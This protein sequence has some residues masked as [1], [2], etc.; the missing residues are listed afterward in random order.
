M[1]KEKT[2]LIIIAHSGLDKKITEQE[3]LNSLTETS[4][5]ERFFID[6]EISDAKLSELY[7]LPFEQLALE[8]QRKFKR[9]IEP[10][11]RQHPNATVAYFGLAP[12][13]LAFQLGVLMNNF[14]KYL[15]F[16]FHHEKKVWYQE[17]SAVEGTE[18]EVLPVELPQKPEKGKGDVFIRVSAS[19]RIEP[20]HTLEVLANPTNE[21]DVSLKK[22]HVDA[23]ANQDRSSYLR[24]DTEI[25]T[26]RLCWQRK[27]SR[28]VRAY[29][30]GG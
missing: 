10:I 18:F 16:Q 14:S 3:C 27:T 8:Q 7:G 9:E 28:R 22:P 6:F 23:L 2:F 25:A 19:Y 5:E 17:I 1:E 12:I 29:Q 20:Q 4:T 30:T 13:P 11:L 24:C 21:F 15:V 26:V